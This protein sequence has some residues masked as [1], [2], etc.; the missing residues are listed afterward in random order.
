[1]DTTN[2]VIGGIYEVEGR[3]FNVGIWTGLSFLGYRIKY[4]QE[5]LYA[6]LPQQDPDEPF[7]HHGTIWN[8]TRL[9]KHVIPPTVM[10]RITQ[11]WDTQEK[12]TIL[13]LLSALEDAIQKKEVPDD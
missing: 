7:R 9:G 12:A 10:F 3:N 2:L 1:M 4:T 6:E 11:D 13:A 8:A 5:S